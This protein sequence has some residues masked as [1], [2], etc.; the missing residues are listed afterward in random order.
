[1]ALA[2]FSI[3]SLIRGGNP[4]W[5]HAKAKWEIVEQIWDKDGGSRKSGLEK[6]L[7]PGVTNQR[8]KQIIFLIPSGYCRITYRLRHTA[9]PT[10][11]GGE[12]GRTG[13]KMLLTPG[14]ILPQVPTATFT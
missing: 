6:P 2:L 5:Y 14:Y 4:P 3:F 11:D 10:F 9:S 7:L 1:M 8:G 13:R 12:R